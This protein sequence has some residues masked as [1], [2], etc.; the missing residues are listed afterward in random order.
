MRVTGHDIPY[1]PAKLEKHHLPDLDRILDGVDRVLGR[2]NSPER[3]GRM[4]AT[5]I[6]EFRLPD[7][8]EG[9]T[10]AEIVAWLVA[11]GDT[12]T[13]NQIIAE[14]ETAKAV[15]ELPS[16]FAGVVAALHAARAPSSRSARRSSR[17]RWR[18]TTAVPAGAAAAC[19][20]TATRR[21]RREP[22]LVGYGAV[23][24]SSGRPARRARSV[25]ARPR[26]VA[27]PAPVAERRRPPR[28]VRRRASPPLPQSAERPRS[29]PPV[30]KLANDL[31]VDLAA[32]TGTGRGGLIT[33]DDV[34]T[35]S[36]AETCRWPRHWPAR[37]QPA[38]A[39]G[40][41]ETAH[42]DQGRA[43]AHR[44]GDGAQRVHRAARDRVPH[45]RCH[46]DDGAARAAPGQPRVRR[47][48][49]RRRSTVVAK[50][51]LIALRRTPDAQLPLGRGQRRRSCSTTT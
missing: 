15:V 14:V 35:S 23:L 36:A 27:E 38:P 11:V 9:L 41:R 39:P 43:Q 48:Q 18:A 2:P 50:A 7:L 26:P 21:P 16:P 44:R 1:P 5:M 6:K 51:V 3:A 24:E 30:R 4:S 29:T 25:A 13:L 34:R 20:L 10:E 19:R 37:P 47:P 32:V 42:P 28:C 49:A 17:S 45:R 12:V 31:G 22:N 46:G 8:G 33:R 40:E